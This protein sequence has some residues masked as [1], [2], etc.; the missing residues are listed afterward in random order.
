[1]RSFT[2]DIFK[3]IDYTEMDE[4]MSR[5]V[6]ECRNLPEIRKYMVNQDIIPFDSHCKFVNNLQCKDNILY[7][8]VLN[9]GGVFVGSI[10]LHFDDA[11][12]AERGIYLNPAH[13]GQGLSKQICKDCYK[14]FRDNH[15]L[16]FITTKV[17]K[18]NISSN[19]LERSLGAVKVAEDERFFYYRC[20][21]S[22]Y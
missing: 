19:A 4:D 6:W 11:Q 8:S 12:S 2:T 15:G 9:R 5:L 10:N 7:Y 1:M 3:Y 18:E 17:L 22:R 14:Y 20:D 13:Q 21:L 16:R